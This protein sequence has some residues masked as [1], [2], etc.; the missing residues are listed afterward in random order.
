MVNAAL[1]LV[2]SSAST[3]GRLK[4]VGTRLIRVPESVEISRDS[5]WPFSWYLR[6]ALLIVTKGD[7]TFLSFPAENGNSRQLAA[8]F[9]VYGGERYDVFFWR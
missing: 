5:I 4:S 1:G 7:T 6:K 3:N 2:K 8:A 9:Y